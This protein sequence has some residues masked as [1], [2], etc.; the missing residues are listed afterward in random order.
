M[1]SASTLG[2]QHEHDGALVS[3]RG[4]RLL[5]LRLGHVPLVADPDRD[6]RPIDASARRRPSA[7]SSFRGVLL[8]PW[9]S[10]SPA[11]A[12]STARRS[13][14][15]RS[16]DIRAASSWIGSSALVEVLRPLGAFFGLKPEL[17]TELHDPTFLDELLENARNVLAQPLAVGREV[18]DEQVGDH[19]RCRADARV[20]DAVVRQ[21][22]DEE[23]ERADARLELAVGR[24]VIE[25]PD[26]LVD[27]LQQHAALQHARRLGAEHE[28]ARRSRVPSGWSATLRAASWTI[29]S[30]VRSTPAL[31]ALSIARSAR[32]QNR[33]RVGRSG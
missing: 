23:D 13:H 15:L 30:C 5:H 28:V 21:L 4:R 10:L 17:V 22:R 19:R 33:R 16:C 25:A 18:L 1:L 29:F 12:S 14:S 26:E 32:S 20:A 9:T 7:A 11:S 3:G 31:P 2:Q 6:R 27:L 24:A 8:S